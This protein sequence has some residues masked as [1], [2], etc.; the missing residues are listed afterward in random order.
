MEER[1]GQSRVDRA[2]NEAEASAERAQQGSEV[3]VAGERLPLRP[4]VAIA[5]F[6]AV[7]VAVDAL[8]WAL[9][10]GIGLALGVVLGAIAGALAAKFYVDRRAA[11][12]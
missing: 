1:A 5:I 10:G 4:F 7:F 6:V 8:T 2:R 12:S 3:S 11:P 9:L